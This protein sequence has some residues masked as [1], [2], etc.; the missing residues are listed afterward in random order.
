[1]IA[2]I[3]AWCVR[4]RLVIVDFALAFAVA[5]ELDLDRAQSRFVQQVPGEL[6]SRPGQVRAVDAM[7][8]EH[9][10]NPPLRTEQGREQD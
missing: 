8:R 3:V 2:A 5:G 7:P 9:M 1:M 10:T 6:A 4:H